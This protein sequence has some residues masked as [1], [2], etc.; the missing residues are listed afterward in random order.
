MRRR[1]AL[2]DPEVLRGLR[3]L[4]AA[5]A[6]EPTADPDLSQ[7]VADVEA[8]RPEPSAAFL[9]S[10]DARVHA[11]F[12]REARR[13][14][15]PA[16]RGMSGS[17]APQIL[18]PGF[19]GRCS[20]PC[21]S[22]ASRCVGSGDD[23]RQRLRIA[24]DV[25][26]RLVLVPPPS[27]ERGREARP[28]SAQRQP[29]PSREQRRRRR[30]RPVAHGRRARGGERRRAAPSRTARSSAPPTSRSP[31]SPTT[32]RRPPTA[33]CAR[34]RPRAATSSAPTSPPATAAARPRSRCG[35]RPPA[36]TTR[37]PGSPSSPTSAR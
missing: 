28:A 30:D 18:A 1:D 29:A 14:R 22:A 33:S 31:P 13:P 9:A 4:D 16:R 21:S 24:L 6:G 19:A 25:A 11:G 27:A 37:S 2:P 10:L 34:P 35:S 15:P 32:S 7:L 3:E 12:P 23:R 8:A 36:W 26:R 20:S 17:A 5:L